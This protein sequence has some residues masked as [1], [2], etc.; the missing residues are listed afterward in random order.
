MH[1]PTEAK[2]DANEP[3]SNGHCREALCAAYPHDSEVRWHGEPNGPLF[4]A[5]LVTLDPPICAC[6]CDA[7]YEIRETH[8]R[9]GRW[10]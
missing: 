9:E 2:I 10:S 3:K 1:V 6:I 4:P 8:I 7:C 5:E